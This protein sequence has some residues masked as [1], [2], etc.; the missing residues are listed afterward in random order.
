MKIGAIYP[1]AEIETDGGA[2]RAFAQGVEAMGYDHILGFDHVLGANRASRPGAFMPYDLD[3]TFQEP[4]VMFSHMAACTKTVGFMTAVLVLP[5]RQAALVA[6]Q[7]AC[8]DILS[9]GRFRLGVGTGWNSVEYESLGMDFATRGKRIEEQVA[10]MRQLW[11]QRAVTFNGQ[12]HTITDAG[13]MPMPVTRPIPVWFGGGNDRVL[14]GKPANLNV[15]RR[16]ARLG[17]GWIQQDMPRERA[18]ELIDTFHGFCREYGRDPAAVGIE[19]VFHLRKGEEDSWS[20]EVPPW[21]D[22]VS[23]M[24]LNTMGQ[25]LFGVDAHLKRFEAFRGAVPDLFKDGARPEVSVA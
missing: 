8:L 14:F 24:G 12:D 25:K 17:D 3:T 2:V 9:E 18:R 10:V 19:A 7:V 11:T 20:D 4:L 22:M 13:L 15:L 16:I 21:R 6:K 23:H 1:Q 5:Q